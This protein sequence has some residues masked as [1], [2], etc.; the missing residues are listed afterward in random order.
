MSSRKRASSRKNKQARRI[1]NNDYQQ[2]EERKL[3]AVDIGTSISSTPL[4]PNQPATANIHG[5]IGPNHIVQFTNDQYTVRTVGG[6][7]Q[8]SLDLEFFF[9]QVAAA[10][11]VIGQDLLNNDIIGDVQD[12]RV[13]FDH[14]SERWFATAVVADENGDNLIGNDILLAVS[15]TANP[16]DGFQSV[17]FVGDTTGQHFNSFASVA[18]NGDGVIITTQNEIDPMNTSVSI[19]TIPKSDLIGETP[20]AINLTRFENLDQELFGNTIQFA[21]NQMVDSTSTFGV[22]TFANGTEISFLE[23]TNIGN[24]D[25]VQLIQTNATVPF[26]AEAPDARQ[27]NDVADLNNISPNITGNAVSQGGFLWTTHTISGSTGTSA[28]RWYQIEES[29]GTVVN[30]GD[31]EDSELDFTYPSIAVNEFGAVAIGFT[32]SGVNSDQAASSYATL[33]F[34]AHGLADVPTVTFPQAPALLQAG[35]SNLVN[36]QDGI[37]PFGEYSATGV[38]PDDPF[39]FFTFQQFVAAEDIWGIS[40]NEVGISGIRPVIDSND[41]GNDVV[42]RRSATNPDRIEFVFDGLVTDTYEFAAVDAYSINLGDGDDTITIDNSQGNVFAIDGFAI[43]GGLGNDTLRVI[44]TAGHQFDIT[45]DGS[46]LFDLTSTFTGFETLASSDGNDVFTAND[47]TTDWTLLG[48]AGNDVF[49][50]RTSAIGNFTLEGMS[51]DDN[52][53]IPLANFSMITINDSEGDNDSLVGLGTPDDDVLTIDIEQDV[54]MGEVPEDV[55]I[56]NDVVIEGFVFAGVENLD[57]DGVQGDD[58]FNI[59]NLTAR[60]TFFGSEGFDTFNVSSAAPGIDGTASTIMAELTIDGGDGPNRLVIGHEVGPAVD[61][62]ISADQIS[63][64]T[65][66]P[67]HYV[68]DFGTGSDGIEGI[69]VNGSNLGPNQFDIRDLLL[70]NSVRVNGGDGNDEF[71]IR[72]SNLG[73]IVVDGGEGSD[74]YRTAFSSTERNILVSDS[75]DDEDGSLDRLSIRATDEIDDLLIQNNRIS[76]SGEVYEWNGVENVILATLQGDD[77]VTIGNNDSNSIRVILAEGDDTGIVNGTVG[78]NAVR[79]DGLD[80]D[81]VFEFNGSSASSFV[82]ARGGEG[83]DQFTLGDNSFGRS[84]VDGEAGNDSVSVTYASRDARRVNTRDSGEGGFDSLNVIGTPLADRLDLRP[85][86][87]DREGEFIAYDEN[88]ESLNI[89]L[90]GSNDIINVFGSSADTLESN[91]GVGNDT[92]N[93]L[94]TSSPKESIELSF[95][96]ATGSDT[97]N[98]ERLS[99]GVRIEVFGQAGDDSFN[100]GST[101]EDNDGNL[102]RI[103]GELFLGGGSETDGFD[104]LQINDVDSGGAPFE[105]ALNDRS[106]THVPGAFNIARPF[107]GFNFGDMEFIFLSGNNQTNSFTVQP[108]Q[109]AIIRIDGNFSP[110]DR[111]FVALAP[112]T[113]VVNQSGN[114]SG[115]GFFEFNNGFRNVSFQEVEGVSAAAADGFGLSLGEN[116]EVDELLADLLDEVTGDI[117]G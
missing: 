108:S 92:L 100:V 35:S 19:Y 114:A 107:A 58:T 50:I 72:G 63:G 53:G 94:S 109:D 45:G 62:M 46:G 24:L 85:R 81:D 2:L 25:P 74:T 60:A 5:D 113:E 95:S 7:E 23:L 18:V 14:D 61:A 105:Y 90:L 82:Q 44:D 117:L 9:G 115:S 103:R 71:Q 32:G 40:I 8:V 30:S 104:T 51:G 59:R 86:I 89:E 27:P 17:Q 80:G 70:G 38:D 29:T 99:E 4:L 84:R 43:D 75:G 73:D 49:D 48:G 10:D 3:L 33:G 101:L 20:S 98:I 36:I 11:I 110:S 42:V 13:V 69:I 15:R 78:T 12:A 102:N 37:N 21:T 116:G 47:S 64:F 55:I 83:N 31:I 65:V 112:G 1:S 39:S 79:F 76:E 41:L 87:I 22:A 66:A 56:F 93:V 97:A 16:I 28:I 54:P 88:T 77:I 67:I 68:G 106:L 57:F 91:L 34:S 96:L 52:Y 26:Y 6:A 111:L